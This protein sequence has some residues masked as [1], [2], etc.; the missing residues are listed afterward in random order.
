MNDYWCVCWISQNGLLGMAEAYMEFEARQLA[1][2][3]N[4]T[5]N[6]ANN[7][8]PQTFY[9]ILHCSEAI[10]ERDTRLYHDDPLS[11]PCPVRRIL[12]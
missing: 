4:N 10:K 7:F 5:N 12:T 3:W 9:F 8:D 2:M 1:N 6:F 11:L